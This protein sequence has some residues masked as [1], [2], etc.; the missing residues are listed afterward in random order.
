MPLERV[1]VS[2]GCST[3]GAQY[4]DG[5]PVCSA[6]C[7]P[8]TRSTVSCE[9]RQVNISFLKPGISV[10]KQ[11]FCSTELHTLLALTLTMCKRTC[12]S[13]LNRNIICCF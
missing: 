4:M 8:I 7:L 2:D 9:S 6:E 1:D 3:R 13:I 11:W 12:E 10:F 5:T